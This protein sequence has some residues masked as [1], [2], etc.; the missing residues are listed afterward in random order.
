ML[1]TH[2]RS[3]PVNKDF[4]GFRV[5]HCISLQLLLLLLHGLL[6]AQ[7]CC[8]LYLEKQGGSLMISLS[9]RFL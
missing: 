9:V 8:R 2:A 5:I 4:E 3:L 1:L 6:S 7:F